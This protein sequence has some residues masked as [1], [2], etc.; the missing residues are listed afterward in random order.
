MRGTATRYVILLG[1][2][3]TALLGCQSAGM[4]FLSL[5]GLRRNPVVVA[6]VAH[7]PSAA[8]E[9][10]F[11]GLNPFAPYEPLRAALA[12]D[13]ARPVALDLCFP[14]Q[15]EPALAS[16]VAHV[17]F[18][19]PGQ[20]AAF[21]AG[22]SLRVVAVPVDF[23]GRSARPAV[24]VVR[25]DANI[26]EVADLRGKT[27][28][29]GPADDTRT[30][31]AAL[32]LLARHGLAPGDLSLELLPIPGSL[33]H[34]PNM[35]AVAQTVMHASS[36]AGFLD[37]SAWEQLP[38]QAERR[39]DPERARLRVIAETLPVPDHLVVVS[40]R[41]DEETIEE[42]RSFLLEAHEDAPELLAPLGVARY[43]PPTE[44]VMDVCRRLAEAGTRAVEP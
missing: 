22:Q 23:Q 27:V 30:H 32:E 20:Y 43:A 15:L 29:F 14:I 24:L 12:K 18:T 6:V 40:P 7:K 5:I 16:G 8:P 10:T 39:D 31:R 17:A 34:M 19:S 25:P 3:V 4:R 37:L 41:L 35:R 36:D 44:D 2:T 13:L 9:G 28:A 26:R 11:F 42:I 38:E 1:L 33:K 21:S